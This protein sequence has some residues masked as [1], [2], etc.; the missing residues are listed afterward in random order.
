MYYK[1][2]AKKD[3]PAKNHKGLNGLSNFSRNHNSNATIL[4]DLMQNMVRKAELA[5][6]AVKITQF[7]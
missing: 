2:I 6:G 1:K 7:A 3:F 4:T 5:D